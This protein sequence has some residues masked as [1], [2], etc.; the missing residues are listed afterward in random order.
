[1]IVAKETNSLAASSGKA[2]G[3]GLSVN[4]SSN[5]AH[6][7]HDPSGE[8]SQLLQQ[9]TAIMSSTFNDAEDWEKLARIAEEN[10]K[11]LEPQYTPLVHE[12]ENE[13]VD[14][15]NLALQNHICD[16]TSDLHGYGLSQEQLHTCVLVYENSMHETSREFQK[17]FET[18]WLRLTGDL[19]FRD[20]A[21]RTLVKLYQDR[22]ND[23]LSS[24]RNLAIT[25]IRRANTPNI[26]SSD[27]AEG[28]GEWT[29]QTRALMERVY[30]QHPKLEGHEKKLLA[31]VSGLSL[32][33]VS[34]WV[35][36]LFIALARSSRV[37]SF[38]FCFFHAD[39]GVDACSLRISDR[40]K[41]GHC[42]RRRVSL[43]RKCQKKSH[44]RQSN[45]PVLF[46]PPLPAPN[47]ALLPSRLHPSTPP[48]HHSAHP[49]L[50]EV[51]QIHGIMLPLM[52]LSNSALN[53][54]RVK[55]RLS[56]SHN[57]PLISTSISS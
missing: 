3:R 8:A 5:E 53:C 29:D 49:H 40:G 39:E 10:R 11:Y 13:L 33:Q 12:S 32:R 50:Q 15:P 7:P 17:S 41:D 21:Q 22:F 36:H 1:M 34:I 14:P 35:S 16:I 18:N 31:E 9:L 2:S 54:Q 46:H 25:L 38:G 42:S 52:Q 37:R 23:Q 45:R 43:K 30:Q 55:L 24:R 27:D 6:D 47:A 20:L 26:T 28:G 56:N 48:V 51:V 19:E 4:K 44:L 57:L